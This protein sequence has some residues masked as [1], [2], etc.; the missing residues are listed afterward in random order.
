M[1]YEEGFSDGRLVVI[2][3]IYLNVLGWGIG[4]LRRRRFRWRYCNSSR[5]LVVLVSGSIG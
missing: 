2:Y 1:V 3:L 4:I 5:F